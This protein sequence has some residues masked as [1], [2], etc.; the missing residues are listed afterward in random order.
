[1]TLAAAFAVPP[2]VEPVSGPLTFARFAAPPNV[3][4]YCGTEDHDG[5]VGNLRA[6]LDGP[7]LIRLCR[8]F[9]G[10]WPYLEL[11]A[12]SAGIADPLDPRVVEAYWIGGPLLKRVRPNDFATHLGTRFRG[13]TEHGEWPWLAS[14]PGGG[15]VPHHSF[16]VLE[17]M[18]RIGMLRAGQVQAILP[19]MGQCLV[20]PARVL[21]TDGDGLLVEA[22]PLLMEDGRLSLGPS[23]RERVTP[24]ASGTQPGDL[25]AVHWGWSCGSITQR[26]SRTLATTLAM[27]LARA[28]ET[29]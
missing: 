29:V 27:A 19:A 14:K 6:G 23:V 5:F 4:G 15:A 10:A 9:E 22:R 28:N 12:W 2:R 25:V 21:G 18:P 24:S 8:S 16:H 13:R 3:L 7:E 1:M 26:Q 20:R 11:I 17:V